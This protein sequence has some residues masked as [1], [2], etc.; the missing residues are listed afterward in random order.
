[1]SRTWLLLTTLAC[2]AD[3]LDGLIEP[4]TGE[5][6][7]V[8]LG[9]LRLTPDG[10][11]AAQADVS[12]ADIGRRSRRL[13]HGDPV[14]TLPVVAAG[15]RIGVRLPI[16][17]LELTAW[18]DRDDAATWTVA[19]TAGGL[20]STDAVSLLAGVQVEPLEHR[21]GL[22]LVHV[23]QIG[24]WVDVWIPA[25]DADQV[26]RGEPATTSPSPSEGD[27]AWIAVPS[28]L[29]DGAEGP[30]FGQLV[31]SGPPAEPSWDADPVSGVRLGEAV[32]GRVPIEVVAPGLVVQAWVEETRLVA[33]PSGLRGWGIGGSGGW[34]CGLGG[35]WP[36]PHLLAGAALYAEPDGPVIGSVL[37]D[38]EVASSDVGPDEAG[39]REVHFDTA[40]GRI[41]VWIAAEDVEI[42]ELW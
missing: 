38:R 25:D 33:P 27:I 41:P 21:P 22:T 37:E 34:G 40:W 30:A 12:P 14:Y 1:M 7:L 10:E 20:V 26:R 5:V 11:P 17:D 24:M 19:E 29:Y 36:R 4:T 3:D 13:P 9:A 35:M 18:V 28:D 6:D 42:P 31:P 16:S 15:G 23:E 2:T 32:A 39:W 8:H